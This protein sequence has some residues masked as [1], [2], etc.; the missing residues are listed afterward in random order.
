MGDPW[1]SGNR[2]V[3]AGLSAGGSQREGEVCQM[4]PDHSKDGFPGGAGW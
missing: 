3:A 2:L 1:E 4:M